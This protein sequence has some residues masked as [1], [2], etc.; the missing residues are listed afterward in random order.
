MVP[1]Y[2]TLGPDT[3]GYVIGHANIE[4]LFIEKKAIK[5]LWNK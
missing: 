4:V 5:N 3:I 2:D 1:L